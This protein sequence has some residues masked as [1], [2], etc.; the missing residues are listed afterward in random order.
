MQPVKFIPKTTTDPI[1]YTHAFHGV[2]C[3]LLQ[4]LR[5]TTD[6]IAGKCPWCRKPYR[7]DCGGLNRHLDTC[8]DKP[9]SPSRGRM[10]HE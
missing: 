4:L 7:S 2:S 8:A 1:W 10:R 6:R 9:H 5:W 3:T